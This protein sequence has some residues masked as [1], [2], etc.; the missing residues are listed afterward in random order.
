VTAQT[1]PAPKLKNVTQQR[2]GHNHKTVQRWHKGAT[3]L[4]EGGLPQD[5]GDVDWASSVMVPLAHRH[6]SAHVST[7]RRVSATR[8]RHSAASCDNSM[9]KDA[10][11]AQTRKKTKGARKRKRSPSPNP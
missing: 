1:L 5:P 6:T 10:H 11:Q 9:R 4:V 3:G 7:L 2:D 8:Q